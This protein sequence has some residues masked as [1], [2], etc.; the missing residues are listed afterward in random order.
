[1]TPYAFLAAIPALL[2]ISG[3]VIFHLIGAHRQSNQI[4]QSI[5][6]KLRQT[7]PDQA[8][9]LE[10]LTARQ[11][12][13]KLRLD[14]HFR[15]LVSNQDF[16]LLQTVTRHEFIKSLV[17]YGLIALLFLISIVAF[18]YLQ[19]RPER[20]QLGLWSLESD[21]PDANGLAVDLDPLVLRWQAKGPQEEMD[22]FL[23]NVQTRRRTESVRTTT[24][25]QR[26]VFSREAC[27]VLLD[28]RSV[29]GRNRVK[30]VARL[31]NTSFES[32]ELPLMVG[33][34]VMALADQERSQVILF[35][36]ID[37]S[38]IDGYSFEAKVLA[39]RRPATDGP[40]TWGGEVRNGRENFPI[41]N[42]A[43]VRWDT[44][45]VIYFGPDDRRLIR[46]EVSY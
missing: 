26:A 27:R 24:T 30:A 19:T 25:E 43:T 4:V 6:G 36:G 44:A 1:M 12:S 45:K 11:V 46:T 22:V 9:A 41:E 20:I 18:V 37:N 39:Y 17:V 28:N 5:V 14:D 7:S 2:A 23:E 13:T 35:A 16:E 32:Q 38:R 8:S 34:K 10:G 42:F 31:K 15:S 21:H 33:I 3:F 40:Q 29:H